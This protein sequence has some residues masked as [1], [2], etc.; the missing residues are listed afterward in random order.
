MI[1]E[2]KVYE[3]GKEWADT[4]SIKADIVS[5][6]QAHTFAQALAAGN[7]TEVRW[8][9]QGLDQGHY[10]GTLYKFGMRCD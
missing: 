7:Q 5:P 6:T 1:I 8:N 10:V 4:P 3:Q 9:I 2:F